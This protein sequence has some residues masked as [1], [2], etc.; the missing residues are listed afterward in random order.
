[1]PV[2]GRLVMGHRGN[3]IRHH[4]VVV[5]VVTTQRRIAFVTYWQ[6]AVSLANIRRD[7]LRLVFITRWEVLSHRQSRRRRPLRAQTRTHTRDTRTD[8]L[9][10]MRVVCSKYRT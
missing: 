3:I 5:A 8:E 2:Y 9:Y 7:Y 4:I 1:M 6:M 10:R